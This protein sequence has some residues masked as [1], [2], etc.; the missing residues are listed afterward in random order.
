[1]SD[2]NKRAAIDRMA[3]RIAQQSNISHTDARRMVVKHLNRADNK[4]RSQ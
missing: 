1:M 4:K 2:N 3:Q